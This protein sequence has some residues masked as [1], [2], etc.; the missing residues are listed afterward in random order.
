VVVPLLGKWLD[1][2]G[3]IEIYNYGS[4]ALPI[5]LA[6]LFG[7]PAIVCGFLGLLLKG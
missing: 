4:A 1:S 5:V 3:A 7:L 2:R 6:L